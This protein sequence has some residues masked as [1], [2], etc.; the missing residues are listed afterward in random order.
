[1]HVALGAGREVRLHHRLE[2]CLVAAVFE[3]RVVVVAAEDE[4]FVVRE[5]G[6][7]EAEVVAAF[8]VRV[9]LT[10]PEVRGQGWKTVTRRGGRPSEAQL[11]QDTRQSLRIVGRAWLAYFRALLPPPLP[12]GLCGPV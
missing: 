3:N 8:V 1:M 7:V 4:R 5:P 10:D 12:G 9:R 6:A 2:L 11:A